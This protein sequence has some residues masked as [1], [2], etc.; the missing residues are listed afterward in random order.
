VGV[1]R[2]GVAG[3]VGRADIL[4][5]PETISVR[6]RCDGVACWLLGWDSCWLGDA[7]RMPGCLDG[8]VVG[9]GVG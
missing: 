5:G 3:L 7:R 6:R 4:L 1:E 9:F 8:S 2:A